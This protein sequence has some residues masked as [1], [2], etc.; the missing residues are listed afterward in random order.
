M[1]YADAS[2]IGKLSDEERQMM[3]QA[4]EERRKFFNIP[5]TA[6]NYCSIC[7]QQIAIPGIFKAMNRFGIGEES[8][9]KRDYKELAESGNVGDQCIG[10]KACEGIC[11]Q[12][13]EISNWMPKIHEILG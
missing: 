8:G 3:K 10:C 9:G 7:P 11:P 12:H 6:C 2:A 4:H 5:C 13:I 1:G